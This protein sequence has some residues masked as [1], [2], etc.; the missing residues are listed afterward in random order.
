MWRIFTRYAMIKKIPPQKKMGI[1]SLKF[2][3]LGRDAV[4]VVEKSVSLKDFLQK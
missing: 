2:E 3:G 4:A 1:V